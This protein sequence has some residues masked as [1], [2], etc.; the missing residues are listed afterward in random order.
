MEG[1]Y[2]GREDKKRYKYIYR[3]TFCCIARGSL[4]VE[5][6]EIESKVYSDQKGLMIT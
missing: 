1:N 3:K 6:F 4:K 5:I 2:D